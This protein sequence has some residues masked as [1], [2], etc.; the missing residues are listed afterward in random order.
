V[1]VVPVGQE[2]VHRAQH[3]PWLGVRREGGGGGVHSGGGVGGVG[4]VEV[5]EVVEV[6]KML[7]Q[8]GAHILLWLVQICHS[9]Y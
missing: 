8:R 9:A 6:W 7:C 5:L 3:Q 4:G 2:V 1:V